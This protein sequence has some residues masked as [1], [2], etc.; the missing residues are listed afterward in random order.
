MPFLYSIFI[1]IIIIGWH[2]MFLKVLH[3]YSWY[4]MI[5]FIIITV[6]LYK[7][8]FK[9]YLFILGVLWLLSMS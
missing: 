6:S 1:I 8:A 3:K 7:S 9:F 5:L 4:D 2:D